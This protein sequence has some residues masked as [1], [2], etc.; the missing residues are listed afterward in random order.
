M[1]LKNFVADPRAEFLADDC[2]VIYDFLPLDVVAEITSIAEAATEEDWNKYP[3]GPLWKGRCLEFNLSPNF[4]SNE[5]N[6]LLGWKYKFVE[7]KVVRKLILGDERPAHYDS[8]ID[9]MCDYGIVIYLNDNYDGGEIYYP[10]KDI[11]YKPVKNSAVIHSA[12]EEYFHGIKPVLSG[13]RYYM[14]LFADRKADKREV[15]QV[16][17]KR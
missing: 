16:Y 3:I 8:Q 15:L 14:T 11:V 5:V 9:P 6:L 7:T 13:T 4:I 10:K 1:P 12:R 17:P 2:C